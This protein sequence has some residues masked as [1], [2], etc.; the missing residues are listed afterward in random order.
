MPYTK[1]INWGQ[2]LR[3]EATLADGGLRGAVDR[4]TE[5]LGRGFGSRPTFA[6][7]FSLDDVPTKP[8]QRERAY[9][10][11]T[12]LGQD[13]AAWG[14]ADFNPPTGWSETLIDLRTDA[15]GWMSR[16]LQHAA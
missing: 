6:E 1:V 15:S 8:I 3:L 7:L 16:T 9:L 2:A 4:I 11:L 5:R 14:L 13:P 12:A 10:L